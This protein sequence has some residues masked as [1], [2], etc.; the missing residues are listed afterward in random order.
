MA[1]L[2]YKLIL[3]VPFK[4]R[5]EAKKMGAV[6]VYDAGIFLYWAVPAGVETDPFSEWAKSTSIKMKDTKINTETPFYSDESN[7]FFMDDS[8][9][10]Q[11]DVKVAAQVVEEKGVTLFSVMSM[12]KSAI[13]NAFPV[14]IWVKA[15]VV[16]VTGSNHT[17]IEL[18][19]YD[20]SGQEKSKARGTIWASNKSMITKWESETGIKLGSGV[21]VLISVIPE[22]SEKFGLSLKILKIDSQFTVG[23]M[24]LKLNKIRDQLIREGCF[25]SNKSM[26]SP[27]EYTNVAVI[28]PDGAAGL[29]DFMSQAEG[30]IRHKICNFDIYHAT[31]QGDKARMSIKSA[32]M[33]IDDKINNG[34]KYDAIVFIRGGGDKSGLNALNEYDIAK[35]ICMSRIPVLVGIGHERDNTIVDELANIRFATPSLVIS[36]IIGTITHNAIKAISDFNKVKKMASDSVMSMKMQTESKFSRMK[37]ISSTKTAEIKKQCQQ[38]MDLVNSSAK[39]MI[40]HASNDCIVKNDKTMDLAKGLIIDAKNKTKMLAQKVIP[41][42]PKRVLSKGYAIIRDSDGKVITSPESAKSGSNIVIQLS[43]GNLSAKVN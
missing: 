3:D 16:S 42:H 34:L 1:I 20:V 43:G 13:T 4:D 40:V 18:S 15:E 25:S 11:P 26:S 36:G 27:K 14:S 28:A 35:S 29:G 38:K 33:L 2:D 22:F 30:L 6:P 32:F 21:K 24:E 7:P 5:F 8:K 10:R 39:A 12:V 31:F 41:Q 23:D 9:Y 19:D 37:L 17:Y